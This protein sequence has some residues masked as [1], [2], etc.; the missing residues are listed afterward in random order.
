MILTKRNPMK[1]NRFFTALLAMLA[2][3]MLLPLSAGRASE[4]FNAE[5]MAT[6]ERVN[7]YFNRMSDLQGEFVQ[8]G[9]DGDLS[10]G[11]FFIRRPGQLRFD[12]A[13]PSPLR[14]IADGYWIAVHD[15]QL[16][17]T[18]RYRL[19]NTPLRLLLLNRVDLV[20]DARILEIHSEPDLTTLTLED[21]SGKAPGQITLVL[22]G[23]ETQLKQ[24]IITD[25]QGL[26][27]SVSISNLLEGIPVSPA[28]FQITEDLL[29]DTTR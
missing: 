17:T 22:A 11:R 28:I 24:W 8:V 12:Y 9:P 16:K 2:I 5:H 23:P 18:D 25:P 26:Q 6:I 21:I 10:E 14:V 20:R 19:S 7:A 15:K 13:S 3:A 4:G 27:T 29:Q 1:S